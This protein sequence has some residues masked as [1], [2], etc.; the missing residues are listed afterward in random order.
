MVFFFTFCLGFTFLLLAVVRLQM[1]DSDVKVPAQKA[2]GTFGIIIVLIGWLYAMA[3]MVG[4]SNA[5][6]IMLVSPSL[7]GQH[8][9]PTL[10]LLAVLFPIERETYR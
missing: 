7:V 4:R 1:V 2:V 9:D 3:G 5:F 8:L 10:T 6:F